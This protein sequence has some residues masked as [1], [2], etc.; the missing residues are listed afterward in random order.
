MTV[1]DPQSWSGEPAEFDDYAAE[2]QGGLDNPI[3]R[4]LGS[5]PDQFIAVKARWL[6]RREPGLRTGGLSILDYGCGVGSLM[7]VLIGLG[8][9]GAFTGCDISTGMLR[10]SA[11]ETSTGTGG[12]TG[13]PDPAG[14]PQ[15]ARPAQRERRAGI[16]IFIEGERRRRAGSNRRQNRRSR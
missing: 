16:R 6:L 2:Y 12:L 3:K 11:A 10:I 1:A 15:A 7:R 13:A 5:S 9:K 14:F 8:A 4:M